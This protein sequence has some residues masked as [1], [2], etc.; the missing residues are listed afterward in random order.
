MAEVGILQLW[1]MA[2]APT[3]RLGLSLGL[4][5]TTEFEEERSQGQ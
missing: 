3:V 1:E 2:E 4:K 5:R